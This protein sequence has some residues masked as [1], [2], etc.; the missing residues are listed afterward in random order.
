MSTDPQVAAGGTGTIYSVVQDSGN[1]AWYV[2]YTE[3]TPAGWQSWVQT[4]GVL[5]TLGPAA[6]GGA[7]FIA[8]RDV[9]NN[10]WWYR[11]TD[12]HWTSIANHGVAAGAFAAA[13]R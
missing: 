9:S 3:G 10:L 4:G 6:L 7:L 2:G 11:S 13:P 8:G 12:S 1:V 5:P